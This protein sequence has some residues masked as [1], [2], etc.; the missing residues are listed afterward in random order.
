MAT[1][2]KTESAERFIPKPA[3]PPPAPVTGIKPWMRKNLFSNTV[4]TIVTLV[5]A[6]L[7][8]T[9]LWN[10]IEWALVD[11]VWEAKNRRDCMNQSMDGACWAGPSLWFNNFMYGRYDAVEQWR[12]NL[13]GIVLVAWLVPLFLSRITAKI[14]TAFSLILTYPL[15]TSY[16]FY[17]GDKGLLWNAASA[18]GLACF[19]IA[20]TNAATELI[21]GRSLGK[22]LEGRFGLGALKARLAVYF[23]FWLLVC[24]VWSFV[25][26][27]IVRTVRWGGLFVTL[28]VSG[29]GITFALPAGIVLALGRR[30]KLPLIRIVCTVF[31][32]VFRSVPLITVLFM[33]TTMVP[34]FLPEGVT[35]DKLLRAIVAVCL[36]AAAYM[37]EVVRGGLQSVPRGQPEAAAALGLDFWKTTG[38]IVM[39]QA[40][41]LMIPNIV[42]NF[43]GLFKDTT[44]VAI[45]GLFDLLGMVKAMSNDTNWIGL[46]DEPYLI[47]AAIY[48]IGCFA[49]SRYARSIEVKLSTEHR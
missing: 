12:V 33:A 39:P 41:K 29:I 14:P 4:D 31:I 19:I 42:S 49:M 8:G 1:T 32:E 25:E 28:V 20:M 21:G 34:L 18:L 38:L 47:A 48:F 5:V 3:L 45:I 36:F 27:D 26:F 30:S 23:V 35:F 7:I 2:E 37:A 16:L 44:L 22:T 43:I 13:G 46:V 9:V 11:A 15:F 6:T 17:G 24:F 10:V 40:L